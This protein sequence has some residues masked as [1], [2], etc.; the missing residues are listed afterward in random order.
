MD[1][2]DEIGRRIDA[3]L[4]SA[5]GQTFLCT[6][7]EVRESITASL[8][9]IRSKLQTRDSPSRADLLYALGR[10]EDVLD[11]VRA[12]I[13]RRDRRHTKTFIRIVRGYQ[14]RIESLLESTHGHG[15]Q[16]GVAREGE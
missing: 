3:H 13:A 5:W 8:L 1:R 7:Q 12:L 4:N 9:G 11:Q 2:M 14:R 16:D 10:C 15:D 6:V